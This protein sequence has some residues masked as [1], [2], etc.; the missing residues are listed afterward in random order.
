MST[1]CLLPPS[2]LKNPIL[3]GR[4]FKALWLLVAFHPLWFHF[5]NRLRRVGL[6]LCGLNLIR[7]IIYGGLTCWDSIPIRINF[8]VCDE[9]FGPGP[10]QRF[11]SDL[12]WLFSY[13][14]SWS[15][16]SSF[17][18]LV[19]WES[20]LLFPHTAPRPKLFFLSTM[21]WP[22]PISSSFRSDR[23]LLWEYWCLDTR[24]GLAIQ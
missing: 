11:L 7:N 19:S 1:S 15:L 3:F 24:L 5:R 9:C 10:L 4:P 22:H 14:G 17:S 2:T 12:A 18:F 20:A 6:V 23:S 21:N 8:Q 13:L 16:R